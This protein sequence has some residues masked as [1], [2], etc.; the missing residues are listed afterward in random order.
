MY[1][2]PLRFNMKTSNEIEKINHLES[3]LIEKATYNKDCSDE[4]YKELIKFFSLNEN[5]KKLLPDIVKS[6]HTLDVFRLRMQEYGGYAYRRKYIFQEMKALKEF[7]SSGMSMCSDSINEVFEKLS[8]DYIRK[9]WSDALSSVTTEPD[10]TLTLA[11]TILEST[12]KYI[13]DDLDESYNEK[14]ELPKLYK[15]VADKLNFFPN[16]HHE[17]IVK[18]I[19]GGCH[20]VVTG[21]GILRNKLSE[22][23][24]RGKTIYEVKPMHAELAINLAGS[25]AVFLFKTYEDMHKIETA[26]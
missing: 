14:D 13:L 8:C 25:L 1:S 2:Q 10:R 5:Y 12:L 21:L 18:Q 4:E 16:Q 3:L 15:S 17:E 22:S 7:I 20:G 23:H 19:L 6:S 11:R 9:K 26:W 24:G